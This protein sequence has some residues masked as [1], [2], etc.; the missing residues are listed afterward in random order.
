MRGMRKP[1]RHSASPL[2]H[3]V[4]AQSMEDAPARGVSSR[5]RLVVM[6]PRGDVGTATAPDL[7]PCLAPTKSRAHL[8][9]G[10]AG[11][12]SCGPSLLLRCGGAP[13][14][15]AAGCHVTAPDANLDVNDPKTVILIARRGGRSSWRQ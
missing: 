12:R 3:G 2:V 10:P 4:L 6:V 14:P 8:I 15:P 9:P 1:P 11:R 13:V 5:G 7:A